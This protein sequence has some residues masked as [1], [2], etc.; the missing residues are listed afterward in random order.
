MAICDHGVCVELFRMLDRLCGSVVSYCAC[1]RWSIV[2]SENRWAAQ[3]RTNTM[4]RECQ[5]IRQFPAA[6]HRNTGERHY[7]MTKRICIVTVIKCCQIYLKVSIGFGEKYP[8]EEC[9]EAIFLMVIQ[10]VIG[11][12]IEGAMVGIVY[13]KMVRPPNKSSDMKFSRKAVVCQRD[14]KLCLQFR[15]CDSNE[16]HV[17]DSKV[18]AYWF[19]ER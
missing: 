15:I 2:W 8:N 12:A 19:E 3:R 5:V 18:H 10:I 14:A 7:W 13:A 6:K 16:L 9:P 11:I 4:R 17:V 1:S